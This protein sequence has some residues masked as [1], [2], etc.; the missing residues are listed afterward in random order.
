MSFRGFL[1]ETAQVFRLPSVD[2]Y[3]FSVS[4]EGEVNES[5]TLQGTVKCRT[6]R[7]RAPTNRLSGGLVESGQTM[8]FFLPT[9]DIQ[10]SDRL[11]IEGNAYR[12]DDTMTIKRKNGRAHHIECLAT[13]ID[14]SFS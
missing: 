14:W 6:D 8:V 12:V 5:W 2:D 9:E 13:V 7:Y 10:D 1:N 11:I 4:E 3:D